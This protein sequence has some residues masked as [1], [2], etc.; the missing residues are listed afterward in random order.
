MKKNIEELTQRLEAGVKAV[1]TSE[2]YKNY[3]SFISKFHRYSAMNS[4]LIFAQ[5]PEATMVA[6]FNDWRNKH[7]RFVRKGEAGI[8]IF[9]PIPRKFEQTIKLENGEEETREIKYT[10]YK[11]VSVFD[12]SQT[13]G[14]P[15]PEGVVKELRE[16]VTDFTELERKLRAVSPVAIETDEITTGAKGYY[17]SVSKTIVINR[18]MAEQQTLKTMIHEIAHAFLHD[19]FTGAEKDAGK[20][21]KEVQAESIAY[22]V[23]NELGVD[24]SDYSFGYI[25]TWSKGSEVKELVNSMNIIKKTAEDITSRVEAA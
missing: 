3:L 18:G 7:K 13:D 25:A 5:F 22:I 19:Y 17:D 4:M 12:I 8:R 11:A 23:C 10:D 1:Y 9:A 21:A 15:V 24:T 2:G 14:E 16:G 6:G 20:N